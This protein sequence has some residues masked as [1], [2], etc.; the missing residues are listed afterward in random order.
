MSSFD[1]NVGTVKSS[2]ETTQNNS[3]SFEEQVEDYKKAYTT[4]KENW[5]FPEADLFQNLANKSYNEL[6]EMKE[7]L[8]EAGVSL[9]NLADDTQATSNANT[10]RFSSM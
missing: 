9:D 3:K 6:I 1:I 7:K 10:N 8:T 2:G 5:T 4:I